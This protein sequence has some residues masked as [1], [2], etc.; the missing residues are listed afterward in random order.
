MAQAQRKPEEERPEEK[1]QLRAVKP[2]EEREEKEQPAEQRPP[3]SST[4]IIGV[5]LAVVAPF[6]PAII[7]L[8]AGVG[9]VVLGIYALGEVRRQE[10]YGNSIAWGS[11]VLGGLVTLL[12][13]IAIIVALL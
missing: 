7:A 4:A 2:E 12:A 11:I 10:R 3:V 8:I 6:L 13:A 1:R 9:A 5:G